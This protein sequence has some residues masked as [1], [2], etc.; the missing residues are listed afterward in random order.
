MSSKMFQRFLTLVLISCM[1]IQLFPMSLK[2]E[3]NSG[4]A[5]ETTSEQIQLNENNG[6]VTNTETENTDEQVFPD[7]TVIPEPTDT[8]ETLEPTASFDASVTPGVTEEPVEKQEPVEEPVEQEQEL[9]ENPEEVVEEQEPE[10]SIEPIV[11]ET[12]E[13]DIELV[14]DGITYLFFGANYVKNESALTDILSRIETDAEYEVIDYVGLTGTFV[15]DSTDDVFTEVTRAHERLNSKTVDVLAG[16][17]YV[18]AAGIQHK[19]S[20]LLYEDKRV[21]VYGVTADSIDNATSATGDA[22]AFSQWISG[23]SDSRTLIVLAESELHAETNEDNKAAKYWHDAFNA[24]AGKRDVIVVYG[25]TAK[26]YLPV[27]SEMKIHKESGDGI[28]D[29]TISYSYVHAG[30]LTSDHSSVIVGI[31][32]DEKAMIK[33][34]LYQTE[35]ELLPLPELQMFESAFLWSDEMLSATTTALEMVIGDLG[36][37]DT[38]PTELGLAMDESNSFALDIDFTGY[39][40]G[41]EIHLQIPVDASVS[42]VNF[43]VYMIGRD[44]SF[45][46]ITD[47]EFENH[48]LQ[49]TVNETGVIV[50][51][52][53]NIEIPET[54]ELVDFR[55]VEGIKNHNILLE[56]GKVNLSLEKLVVVATFSNGE[57]TVAKEI[58]WAGASGDR[59]LGY[60]ESFDSNIIG[61]KQ[62]V[63]LSYEYNGVVLT[64]YFPIWIY[65]G[66]Y[67]DESENVGLSFSD[68][69]VSG[70]TVNKVID[71]A[72]VDRAVSSILSN[73]VAYDITVDGF[74]KG[75]VATVTLPIPEGVVKPAVFYVNEKTGAIENMNC[76]ISADGKSVVFKTTHFSVYAVGQTEIDITPTFAVIET[77]DQATMTVWKLVE[78]LTDGK[79]YLIVDRNTA[80]SGNALSKTTSY[81]NYSVKSKTVTVNAADSKVATVYI[82]DDGLDT[83]TIEWKRTGQ[84]LANGSQWLRRNNSNGWKVAIGNN[85]NNNTWTYNNYSLSFKS[86]NQTYYL[87]PYWS[88][89]STASSVYF[90]EETSVNYDITTSVSYGIEILLNGESKSSITIPDN[91]KPIDLGLAYTKDNLKVDSDSLEGLSDLKWEVV[92]GGNVIDID[93]TTG[94]ITLK[95]NDAGLNVAGQAV[96]KVS[97][98]ISGKEMTDYLVVDVTTPMSVVIVDE[99]NQPVEDRVVVK[100]VTNGMQKTL[101]PL[102]YD[103]DGLNISAVNEVIWSSDNKGVAD[104]TNGVVTFTGNDGT[105]TITV[106]YKNGFG[107]I[108]SDSVVFSA[109]KTSFTVPSDGTDDFP[110]YPNEGAIRFDKHAQA[111]GNFSDTGVVQ[112]E[113]SMT[114]VP[115]T[116]G[117]EIDVVIMLDMSTSMVDGDVDRKTPT[118]T[119]AQEALR[120]L[121]QNEDKSFNGNRVAIYGFNGWHDKTNQDAEYAYDYNENHIEDVFEYAPENNGQENRDNYNVSRIAPMQE[122]NQS[123][124][125]TTFNDIESKYTLQGGTNYAAALRQAYLTLENTKIAGRDQYLIF[126]T[127]G[128]ASTGFSYITTGDNYDVYESYEVTRYYWY[129]YQ[130]ENEGDVLGNSGLNGIQ[131]LALDKKKEY[132]STMMKNNGVEIFT[133]GFQ[134]GQGVTDTPGEIE[135]G[136]TVLKNIAGTSAGNATTEEYADHA[137]FIEVNDNPAKIVE[138]FKDIAQSIKQAATNVLVTDKIADEYTMIFDFPEN[139][140]S[141]HFPEKQE[142]FI[143]VLDYKLRAETDSKGNVTDYVREDNPQSLSKIYLEKDTSGN[144][145]AADSQGNSLPGLVFEQVQ[146]DTE[147]K[148]YGYW[149]DVA[150]AVEADVTVGNSHYKFMPMGD[151]TH[152]IKSG[153]YVSGNDNQN[154]KIITPYFIYDAST[155]ILLW[156]SQKLSSSE[157]ALSYFLYL[158]ESAGW[159]GLPEQTD[160]G[161]YVTNDYAMI[162]YENHL[163]NICQ[164]EF[165]VPQMTWHGAQ[166]SYVFYLVNDAGQPV[167]RAGRVVPFSEAVYVTDVFTKSVVWNDLEET[168]SLESELLAQDLLPDVYELF[169]HS[170]AY[171]IHVFE[172]ETGMDLNNHFMIIGE[173]TKANTTYVFNTKSDRDKYNKPGIYSAKKPILCKNYN[174]TAEQ[175]TDAQGNQYYV[176]TYNDS[177][178]FQQYID[179]D[180]NKPI[181]EIEVDEDGTLKFYTIVYRSDTTPVTGVDFANTTVA[182]AVMWKPRLAQDTIV[183]DYGLP[184][185]VNVALNDNLSSTV[186]GVLTTAPNVEIDVGTYKK[187]ENFSNSVTTTFGTASV[188]SNTSVVYTLTDM[189]INTYDRFYYESSVSYY[190]G[191]ALKNTNMYSSVTVIPATNIYYEDNFKD[192]SGNSFVKFDGYRAEDYDEESKTPIF[193]TTSTV[194][195]DEV[196]SPVNAYQQTDRPGP[197]KIGLSYDADNVY[198]YDDAYKECS[199]YSLGSA[200]KFTAS[201]Q[202]YG[203]ASFEFYGTGFDI[204]SLTSNTTGT[205][206]VDVYK[207]GDTDPVETYIVDT[208]Y[209][210]TYDGQWRL[211]PNNPN[212]LYQIPVISVEGLTYGKYKAVISVIYSPNFDHQKD[213]SYDFYLDAVRIFDPAADTIEIKDP[214]TDGQEST[215]SSGTNTTEKDP[216]YI[217]DVYLADGEYKPEYHEL[218]NWIISANTFAK[219]GQEYTPGIVFIDGIPKLSDADNTDKVINNTGT[220]DTL[221]TEDENRDNDVTLSFSITDYKNFGPNNELYL[222]AGQAISF[223]LNAELSGDLSM[224]DVRVQIGLKTPTGS[225]TY[226]IAGVDTTNTKLTVEE[227]I[228][229]GTSSTLSTATEMYYDIT[230][231]NN[232]TIVIQNVTE[233]KT[234]ANGKEIASILAITNIKITAALKEETETASAS[235]GLVNTAI[236]TPLMFGLM[237]V[238]AEEEFPLFSVN[239]VSTRK[240]MWALNGGRHSSIVEAPSDDQKLPVGPEAPEDELV[241]VIEPTDLVVDPGDLPEIAEKREESIFEQLKPE[242]FF[243]QFNVF[244]PQSDN[245]FIRVLSFIANFFAEFVLWLKQLLGF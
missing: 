107:E 179:L 231:L 21:V 133:V 22:Y 91:S 8:Q 208:Y 175:K 17:S 239:P 220:Q 174:V 123:T 202:K 11:E 200:M 161:T 50:Y 244:D 132:Y 54:A 155:R 201:L 104:V 131:K 188:E 170:A 197:D 243:E 23:I 18:D 143:E 227:Q 191:N 237:T 100:S 210:Y 49:L 53:K 168:T 66:K 82:V 90:Y 33:Y 226:K 126:M 57:K 72:I 157:L 205:I 125:N 134:V 142:F 25:G 62:E 223:D 85:D 10:E 193:S 242:D 109:T 139:H 216:T 130:Y 233:S 234:D 195:W 241:E 13:P 232:K 30:N 35:P 189:T 42:K 140:T 176:Y 65:L 182:F 124:F 3:Q 229:R 144:Y 145:F 111:V 225:A 88:L 41:E 59:T 211:E 127:D 222:N 47:F 156:T 31:T 217:K 196:G 86:W 203:T 37:Y 40:S 75:N 74:M 120:I 165:P 172:N 93:Q 52:T 81:G 183:I 178:N 137:M 76:E 185:S 1:L 148:I 214:A 187:D 64:D 171:Q 190:E 224:Y 44:N 38:L 121:V 16:G 97:Q 101:E 20:G 24:A 19:E 151:G 221:N 192:S 51:G 106:S 206:L 78:S 7:P 34:D 5:E 45:V 207:E 228:D 129:G 27:G 95:Q 71:N 215:G 194:Q 43:V 110:E 56:D 32:D 99:A 73:Y 92:A 180:T 238:D 162:R 63:E 103:K 113:L 198:G 181:Y 36:V 204:I 98:K 199:T 173:S 169:D 240:I 167:N 29:T 89:S 152:I 80:G 166:V 96:I 61:K 218:R 116:T 115:Y 184:V 108:V 177:Q 14:D 141:S 164:Q 245:I 46:E 12:E 119:A 55:I 128:F 212:A 236:I 186:K 15:M 158:D 79:L 28:V 60:V 153:A 4:N 6:E 160:P 159:E 102:F 9:V 26:D 39:K 235:H 83:T 136:K 149:S 94:E 84:K 146:S 147:E 58:D 213:G 67:V 117:N 163:G 219:L 77:T 2:A 150:S 122:Y 48:L 105:A 112:V 154:I 69:G 230:D 70:I 114:G 118:I 135:A 87:N 138:I 68:S 209:G